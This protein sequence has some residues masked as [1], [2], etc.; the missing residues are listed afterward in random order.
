MYPQPEYRVTDRMRILEFIRAHPLATVTA[1]GEDGWPV[2]THVPL[3]T[4]EQGDSLTLRGHVMRKTDHWHAFNA[5]RKAL[6]VFHGPNCP[7]LASWYPEKDNGG[8]WNYMVAHVRGTL[9]W[10]GQ[11]DLVALL[12]ELKDGFEGQAGHFDSLST[13]YVARLLPA[14]QAF[15]LT[16]EKIEAVFKLSQNRDD[17]SFAE[18]V[19]QLD[20]RGGESSAVALEMRRCRP[21][22]GPAEGGQA[23]GDRSGP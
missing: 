6:A 21:H 15:E 18:V 12:R 10:L 5:N 11:E 16:V 3:V 1:Q 8:T 19:R 20:L 22:L 7:V 2:A 23:T 13:E 4:R 14:I 9:T 17:D